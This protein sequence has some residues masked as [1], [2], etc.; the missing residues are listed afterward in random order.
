M[1]FLYKFSLRNE[2]EIRQDLPAR[3]AFV[4][5]DNMSDAVN[6]YVDSKSLVQSV[7]FVSPVVVVPSREV[8]DPLPDIIPL[9][10]IIYLDDKD[11][12]HSVVVRAADKICAY[13]KLC[14][15]LGYSVKVNDTY[16]VD[17]QI[18]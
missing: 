4:A 13:N 15:Y 10:F 11:D 6:G 17:R 9:F 5:A 14:E 8:S 18:L 3:T 7:D 2:Q 12:I 16:I 1:K